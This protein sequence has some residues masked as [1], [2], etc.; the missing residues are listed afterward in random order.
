MTM[1]VEALTGEATR[2][3]NGPTFQI[4]HSDFVIV[5]LALQ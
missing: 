3:I 1:N 2:E 4:Y 5:L